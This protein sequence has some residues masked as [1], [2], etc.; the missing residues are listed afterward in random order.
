M[1]RIWIP[2]DAAGSSSDIHGTRDQGANESIQGQGSELLFYRARQGNVR[3][4]DRVLP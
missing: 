1:C 3:E 4:R 2:P